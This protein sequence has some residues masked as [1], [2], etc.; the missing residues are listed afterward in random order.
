MTLTMTVP[1][2]AVATSS[3][4]TAKSVPAGSKGIA[5]YAYLAS[6]TQPSTPAFVGDLE[7]PATN[8]NTQIC[9]PVTGGV[10]C[11]ITF[12]APVGTD[13]IAVQLYDTAP[14]GGAIPKSATLL[15][16]GT[17]SGGTVT[18]NAN[19]SNPISISINSASATIGAG[20]GTVGTFTP[21]GSST[22][23][24]GSIGFSIPSGAVG[25]NVQVGVSEV[26]T[27]FI[28]LSNQ[29]KPLFTQGAGNTFV[30]GFAITF[31]PST[32]LS[33]PLSINASFQVTGSLASSLA[34]SGSLNVAQWTGSTYND[35]G[36]ASYTYSGGTLTINGASTGVTTSGIYILYIPA[37]GTAVTPPPS[38]G[39]SS[40]S[41]TG[42]IAVL[43]TNGTT[44]AYV[45]TTS[46]L[47]QVP[48]ANGS[49]LL[50]AGGTGS[51]V[52]PAVD[53]CTADAFHG[54]VYC[55]A[56]AGTSIYAY[57]VSSG[58]LSSPT[59]IATNASTLRQFSGGNCYLCG[60]VYD[61]VQNRL[62]LSTSA[63]YETCPTSGSCSTPSIS[64]ATPIAENFGY[65]ASTQQI[66]SPYYLGSNYSNNSSTS[67]NVV[68]LASGS[69]GAYAIS[70][71]PALLAGPDHGAVDTTTGIGIT[72]NECNNSGCGGG[73]S[74]QGYLFGLGAASLNSGNMT[75]TAPTQSIS[76]TSSA[77]SA[78]S[79]ATDGI[80]VDT[81]SHYAFFNSEF[82]SGVIGV[83]KLPTSSGGITSGLSD[84][85]FADMP[86]APNGAWQDSYDPH[87]LTVFNLP[88][89]CADCAVIANLS[90]SYVAVVDL[91][92]FLTATRS[93]DAN[94]V[95]TAQ[96]TAKTS[97]NSIVTFIYTNLPGSC[98]SACSSA[99]STTTIRRQPY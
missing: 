26:L 60:I 76:M 93:G 69:Q 95:S 49:G 75:F 30:Y 79:Y 94:T 18:I 46:G 34:S 54:V 56:F 80:A 44:Y 23:T 77:L 61:T 5:V 73:S 81:N 7:V 40:A 89:V 88:G 98:R 9:S 6:G 13:I 41:S 58:T 24:G 55:I 31:S 36:Y 12:S 35:V 99:R 78:C 83:A 14:S 51:P 85:V 50:T 19:G 66:F 8:G 39:S 71:V 87:A 53:A 28:P 84:W 72:T 33:S 38:V 3:T 10:S 57:N 22:I 86:A 91:N 67:V 25:G 45:P 37:P 20:G 64:I 63:G 68:S 90:R 1:S 21:T 48:L 43:T 52:A 15:A 27:L 62:I 4:R 97:G 96:L 47:L 65:N 2:G 74:A 29:R 92:Q 16:A 11:T 32:T 42:A 17:P 82:C 59:T 70:S